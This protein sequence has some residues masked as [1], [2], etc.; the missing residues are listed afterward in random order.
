PS[1]VAMRL[2]TAYQA[3]QAVT[4]A[5]RLGIPDLLG[6]GPMTS[7]E[8]ARATATQPDM[9]LRLLRALAAFAVVKDL[10]SGTFALT[11]IGDALRAGVPD[12]VRPF[13]L[14]AGSESHWQTFATLA[15]CLRT[16]RSAFEILYGLEGSFAFYESHPDQARAFDDA[17]SAGSAFTGRAAT[18]T[19]DFTGLSRVVDV[20]GGHGKVLASILKAHAHLRGTLFDLPRVVEGAPSLLVADGVADRCEVVGGDMFVAVPAGGDLYL[21]CHVIHDWDDRLATK[22]LRAC[23]RAMAPAAK[24]LILDLVMPE[25]IAPSPTAQANVLADL[26]MM[27]ATGGGRERTAAEFE[28][29]LGAA[30]LRLQRVLPIGASASLLEATPA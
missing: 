28:A 24:L 20:G 26:R 25:R 16:G 2:V 8:I 11:P 12:T 13:A 27:V 17:M 18:E 23:R 9:M 15:E 10:G 19:Y 5:A 21:L 7:G 29:L 4:V 1:A 14:W 6:E 3:S 30:D 22:V